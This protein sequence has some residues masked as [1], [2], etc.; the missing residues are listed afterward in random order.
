[1]EEILSILLIIALITSVSILIQK[2]KKAGVTGVKSALTSI[3]FYLIAIT[4]LTAYWFGF[5]GIFKWTLT[6]ILL[7]AGAYFTKYLAPAA[8]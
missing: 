6:I 4:N 5:L 2:R 1:M 3:C 7:I 8:A